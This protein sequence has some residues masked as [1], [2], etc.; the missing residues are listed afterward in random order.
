VDG[1]QK[2]DEVFVMVYEEES[3]LPVGFFIYCS[4][5]HKKE[6]NVMIRM[7]TNHLD[8]MIKSLSYASKGVKLNWD[9]R[10]GCY[11]L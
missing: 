8:R 7:I 3:D 9:R 4:H 2:I 1:Y 11:T 10:V 5:S 6:S